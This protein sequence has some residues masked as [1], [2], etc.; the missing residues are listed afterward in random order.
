MTFC[1]YCGA[2]LKEGAKFCPSCGKVLEEG[3][4][5]VELVPEK[6][7]QDNKVMA[8][9]AYIIFFVPLLAGAHKTSTFVKFHTNQGTVLIITAVAYSIVT[10]LF[11]G[12]LSI[13][14]L[15]LGSIFSAIFSWGSLAFF[16][17]MIVGI[18]N[19]SNGKKEPLPVIGGFTIIK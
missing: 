12:I 14:N 2:E 9:L 10:G 16:A 11:S 1:K 7:A 3:A 19:V 17:L 15:G 5:E 8:I 13:I 4:P 18:L 6:D